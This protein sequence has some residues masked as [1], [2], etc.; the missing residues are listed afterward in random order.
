MKLFGLNIFTQFW[1][2][3]YNS[4]LFSDEHNSRTKSLF[5]RF[6]PRATKQ[7]SFRG[8][9]QKVFFFRLVDV[10]YANIDISPL[11]HPLLNTEQN[12]RKLTVL[13]CLPNFNKELRIF[14]SHNF[15]RLIS[16]GGGRWRSNGRC[17]ETV[18]GPEHGSMSITF[19][20]GSGVPVDRR[21]TDHEAW[22]QPT[23]H[24]A[25]KSFPPRHFFWTPVF[26][27]FPRT[28][29]GGA[30]DPSSS[31]GAILG[32]PPPPGRD[33]RKTSKYAFFAR[34]PRR[35]LGS[36][37]YL[38]ARKVFM[39]HSDFFLRFAIFNDSSPHLRRLLVTY[40]PRGFPNLAQNPTNEDI[41]IGPHYY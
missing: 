12:A 16:W 6:A 20:G 21:G 22:L 2:I 23:A 8:R 41:E 40:F 25:R 7:V 3:L 34:I 33:A 14:L 28:P 19:R 13:P 36:V 32:W 10:S 15:L 9:N 17:S 26:F 30:G 27:W 37:F 39:T 35:V 11:F 31:I 18:G 24:P 1:E 29:G 4:P 5:R 38:S